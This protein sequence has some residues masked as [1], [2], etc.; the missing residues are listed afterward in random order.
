LLAKLPQEK[1]LHD[2]DDGDDRKQFNQG[3]SETFCH[4]I[5]WLVGSPLDLVTT[6]DS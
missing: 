3:E 1:R 6:R 2:R 4:A 5:S